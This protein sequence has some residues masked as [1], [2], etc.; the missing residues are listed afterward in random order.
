MRYVDA[1]CWARV[2]SVLLLFV[3][4]DGQFPSS[5]QLERE[6]SADCVG[7]YFDCQMTRL[8]GLT[9]RAPADVHRGYSGPSA[10]IGSSRPGGSRGRIQDRIE[11]CL[12]RGAHGGN[13]LCD[14][15]PDVIVFS[16]SVAV[17]GKG[18]RSSRGGAAA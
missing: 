6:S 16:E 11:G 1:L 12:G 15:Q 17:V 10:G 3:G 13:W 9:A 8:E 5:E 4:G 18:D 2:H 14:E 7:V